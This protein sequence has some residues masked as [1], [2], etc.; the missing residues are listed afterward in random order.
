MLHAVDTDMGFNSAKFNTK[1]NY[2]YVPSN[3]HQYITGD[4]EKL[5]HDRITIGIIE[6]P[7]SKSQ[8]LKNGQVIK[9][10]EDMG[11]DNKTAKSYLSEYEKHNSSSDSTKSYTFTDT[12][13]GIEYELK[14]MTDE[15]I[16][17]M[18]GEKFQTNDDLTE[19]NKRI[20]EGREAFREFSNK[21]IEVSQIKGSG[22]ISYDEYLDIVSITETPFDV[23]SETEYEVLKK[24]DRDTGSNHIKNDIDARIS[25]MVKNQTKQTLGNL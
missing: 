1:M 3:S 15:E 20:E 13:T 11:V 7:N 12:N 23:I 21:M 5:G 25:V 2:I 22:D 6:R 18:E 9:M 24:E 16:K 14:S 19:V 17:K 10:L 4:G 8:D